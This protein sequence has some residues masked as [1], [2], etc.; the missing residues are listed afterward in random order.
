MKVLKSRMLASLVVAGTLPAVAAADEAPVWL[1][2]RRIIG[3]N[4]LEPIES[5]RGTAAYDL[6]R[7]VARVETKADGEGFCTGSRVGEDLFL[8]NYHCYEFVPCEDIQFHLGYEKDLPGS[9][10]LLFGCK[11][12]LSSSLPFDYAL[13]RVEFRGTVAGAGITKTYAYDNIN[14]AIPDADDTGVERT[15]TIP[16]TGALV[17]LEVAVKLTHTYVGDLYLTLTSPAGTEVTLHDRSGG[18]ADDLDRTY[19]FTQL[20]ILH[21]EDPKGV[22]KLRLKDLVAQDTGTLQQVVFT[23]TTAAETTPEQG[24][25]SGRTPA[26]YPVAALWDGAIAVGQEL[27]VASHPAARLKEIDRSASC[28][29]RTV[30]TE[31]HSERQTITHTCDTEGGSSGSPVL[32]RATGRIVALHWGGQ[33]DFNMA[34]PIAKVLADLRE[35]LTPELLAELRIESDA[36]QQER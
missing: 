21:G 19:D 16:S 8:T 2:E 26:D 18:S 22:W 29:L 5:A 17:D 12:V 14:L 33:D 6:A 32:D 4:D 25:P 11:E 10:Q 20:G 3:Q 27:I 9:E 13:Y 1:R 34:I 15:F 28:V 35:H 24:E 23:V 36:G 31:E 7:V 30:D